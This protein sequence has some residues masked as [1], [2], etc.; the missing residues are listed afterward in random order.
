[1]KYRLKQNW[2]VYKAGEVIECVLDDDEPDYVDPKV[3]GMSMA[4]PHDHP[5]WFERVDE[6]ERWRPK[7]LETYWYVGTMGDVHYDHGRSN[8]L[9]DEARFDFGNCFQTEAEALAARDKVRDLFLSLR[10]V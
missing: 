9:A 10:K 6:A 8:S 5:D 7:A 4:M 1:M 3:P 2:G